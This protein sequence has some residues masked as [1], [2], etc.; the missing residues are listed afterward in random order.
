M[1]MKKIGLALF[2]ITFMG[3]IVLA[4]HKKAMQK[5]S[6]ENSLQEF[7]QAMLDSDTLKLSKLTDNQLTY[8]HSSGKVQDKIA[9]L[10]SFSSGA[11]DFVKIDILEEHIQYFGNVAVVRHILS[12]DTND[13]KQ[14]GHTDLKILLVWTLEKNNWKLITRQA[15]K[16][17]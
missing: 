12:A 13:N 8:G 6:V 14:S 9:F 4:Q 11:T 3:N 2:A 17:K 15:V 16:Y 7:K 5:I 10:E 1:K